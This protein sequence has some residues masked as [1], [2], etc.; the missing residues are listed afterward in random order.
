MTNALRNNST[1]GIGMNQENKGSVANDVYR[2]DSPVPVFQMLN[3]LLRYWRLLLSLPLLLGFVVGLRTITQDRSYIASASFM[4]HASDSRGASASSALARQFGVRLAGERTGDTPQLYADLL[5]GRTLLRQAVE[6]PYSVPRE[7][8]QIDQM[9][10]VELYDISPEEGY[11]PVWL[12]AVERLRGSMG[13]SVARETG[14]VSVT[15]SGRDPVV[16]EQVVDRLLELVNIFNLETQQSRARAESQ[17][18]EDRLREAQTELAQSENQLQT[19]LQQNR[20]FTNSPELVFEH[21]RLQRQ[22]AMRQEMYTS[23]AQALEQA[24]F[25]AVRDLP[26]IRVIDAANGSAAPVA[27]GTVNRTLLALVLGL[28]LS[29]GAAI[30]IELMRR[31]VRSE[32]EAKAEFSQLRLELW[33]DLRHPGRWFRRTGGRPAGTDHVDSKILR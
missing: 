23:L 6:H 19:F 16:A 22:V 30:V 8:G 28:L 17:F 4:L 18:V 21:D 15:V 27:R 25:D 31:P 9:S 20:L 1:E 5:R 24:R 14:V 2:E 13:V 32:R 7:S 11:P 10:L 33:A 12:K 29:S 3:G 26:V